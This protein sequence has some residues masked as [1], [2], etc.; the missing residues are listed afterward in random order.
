MAIARTTIRTPPRV[1]TPKP[2]SAPRTVLI[3]PQPTKSATPTLLSRNI[4][5]PDGAISSPKEPTPTKK[6]PLTPAQKAAAAGIAQRAAQASQNAGAAAQK[7]AAA[8]ARLMAAAQKVAKHN[9]RVGAKLQ[10]FAGKLNQKAGAVGKAA[11]D[12][13]RQQ[14]RAM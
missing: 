13:A 10:A 2:A 3:K 12:L 8:A 5:L 4:K 1:T 6:A 7:G 11:A 14:R 9:P